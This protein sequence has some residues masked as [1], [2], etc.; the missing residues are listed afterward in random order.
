MIP[1]CLGGYLRHFCSLR[2]GALWLLCFNGAEY[3]HSY[4]LTYL[5]TKKNLGSP[6]VSSTVL[7]HWSELF[8]CRIINVW[9]SLYPLQSVSIPL[10]ALSIHWRMLTSWCI[11]SVISVMSITYRVCVFFVLVNCW[12]HSCALLSSW[13]VIVGL[14][15]SLPNV[16]SLIINHR[17]HSSQ[18]PKC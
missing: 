14:L 16:C 3:K 2:L 7:L 13:N 17:I 15:V 6:Y 8:A 4:L 18:T 11:W 12:C 9:N 1:P 10:S 5:L